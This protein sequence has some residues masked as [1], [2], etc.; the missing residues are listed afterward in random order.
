MPVRQ[1]RPDALL[2]G[3]KVY[4][5]APSPADR[6]EF[7]AL[8]HDSRRL[9]RG[10]VSPPED[11]AAFDSYLERCTRPNFV[12]LLLCRAEDGRLLGVFNLSEIVRGNF[13]S[14]YLGYYAGEPYAGRGYMTEG[15][16][17]VLRH[18]FENL[19][20]H[21]IEANIQPTNVASIRL[22]RRAGFTQEGFS[23]HYLKISGRWRDHERWA[24]LAEDW[25]KS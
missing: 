24:L 11:D 13:Q 5:R 7:I 9:H 3:A 20:L 21:R 12:G 25:K 8:T 2:E 1:K 16:R 14:A 19:K 15:L 22:A 4:I 18:A 23:R 10:L 17:L 6:E